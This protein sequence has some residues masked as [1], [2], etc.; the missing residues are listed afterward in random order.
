MP[1]MSGK[2]KPK[3]ASISFHCTIC[4][5]NMNHTDRPPVILPCGHTYL[6]ETCADRLDKCMECREPLTRT[7]NPPK[8]EPVS[9]SR[10]NVV[11]K[12]K[13]PEVLRLPTPRNHVLMCLMESVEDE[14]TK[15]NKDETGNESLN[16]DDLVN[17]SMKVVG[18]SSGTYVVRKEEGI[19][20]YQNEE[21]KT[22]Q[23][24]SVLF[25]TKINKSSNKSPIGTIGYGKSVQILSFENGIATLARGIGHMVVEKDSDLVKVAELKDSIGKQ[26]VKYQVMEITLDKE[27]LELE[28]R[29]KDIKKKRDEIRKKVALIGSSESVPSESVFNKEDDKEQDVQDLW[30]AYGMEHD[31]GDDNSSITTISSVQS[32]PIPSDFNFGLG[33]GQEVV[34]TSFSYDEVTAQAAGDGACGVTRHIFTWDDSAQEQLQQQNQRRQQH[35]R[36]ESGSLNG[37]IHSY[38]R[39]SVDF[40]SGM[41]GH[42]AVHRNPRRPTSTKR[43]VRIHYR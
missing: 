35:Q 38:S 8:L 14:L 19:K 32:S 31:K 1:Q 12:K 22:W 9:A 16:E 21:K 40:S 41:S 15:E 11:A 36:R 30:E 24:S 23:L 25:S 42:R 5:E 26:Q 34:E 20:V 6:C 3:G 18:S 37:S 43:N 33:S 17:V 39:A 4:F 28:Q 29:L 13:K 7:R 2:T 10:N 27:A